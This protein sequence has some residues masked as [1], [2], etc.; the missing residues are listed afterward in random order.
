[1]DRSGSSR[2]WP[3]SRGHTAS[4]LPLYHI[5]KNDLRVSPMLQQPTEIRRSTNSTGGSYR[6]NSLS[7]EGRDLVI[8]N[9]VKA[10]VKGRGPHSDFFAHFELVPPFSAAE[11]AIENKILSPE[12]RRN[13]QTPHVQSVLVLGTKPYPTPSAQKDIRIAV[14]AEGT[15]LIGRVSCH[16]DGLGYDHS[17]NYNL[18]GWWTAASSQV[19]RSQSRLNRWVS[20]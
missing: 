7:A 8:A 6:K 2:E 19:V 12:L 3:F 9:C 1:M 15:P 18:P 17:Q 5:S 4:V 10:S 14:L 16:R 20:A 13:L 11:R